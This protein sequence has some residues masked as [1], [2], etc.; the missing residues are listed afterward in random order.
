MSKLNEDVQKIHENTD[1]KVSSAGVTK[2]GEFQYSHGGRVAA[3]LSYH[4]H[5]TNS[6]E[7]VFMLGPSHN[8]TS[9]IIEKLNGDQTVF[10]QY[11]DLKISV[12]KDYPEKNL[13]NP[14]ENDYG[15]GTITRFFTQKANDLNSEIYEILQEDFSNQHELF[16]FVEIEWRITGT[17]YEVIRDN[18]KTI[19]ETTRIRGNKM[20]SKKLYPLQFWKPSLDSVDILQR[21]LGRLKLY[22]F[23]PPTEYIPPSPL[24]PPSLPPNRNEMEDLLDTPQFVINP[25]TGERVNIDDLSNIVY[26]EDG[27]MVIG[28]ADGTRVDLTETGP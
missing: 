11:T 23:I 10:S 14:T 8:S 15:V 3:G 21:K 18:M 24:S 27:N 1:F 2:L 25:A 5:Y 22:K 19:F 16:R 13:A 12:R 17:R 9:K 6:K 20:L 28:F 4:I 26:D 7:E